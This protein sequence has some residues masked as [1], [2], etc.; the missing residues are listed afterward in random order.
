MSHRDLLPIACTLDLA[1]GAAKVEA[2][3]L[4]GAEYRRRVARTSGSVVVH[5][6]NLPGAR[7]RLAALVETERECCAFVDWRIDDASEEL[8]LIVTGD[9]FA[10]STLLFLDP[11]AA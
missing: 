9:D 10:L 1:T 7:D 3:R 4:F 8:R 11:D 6:A 5:Y 2:W